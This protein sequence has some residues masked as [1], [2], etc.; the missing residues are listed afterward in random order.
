MTARE[1]IQ[2]IAANLERK[3]EQAARVLTKAARLAA[4][5]GAVADARPGDQAA[6]RQARQAAAT[7]RRIARLADQADADADA[8]RVGADARLMAARVAVFTV[9]GAA[10]GADVYQ[11]EDH[12]APGLGPAAVS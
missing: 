6:E 12:E 8:A 7:F 3:A 2:E 1:A 11:D 5:A 10:F 9:D 4:A